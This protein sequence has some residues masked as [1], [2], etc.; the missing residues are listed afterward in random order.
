MMDGMEKRWWL[1]LRTCLPVSTRLSAPV[2]TNMG[3]R[4]LALTARIPSSILSIAL[5]ARGVARTDRRPRH[6]FARSE[7]YMHVGVS[8]V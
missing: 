5:K 7:R 1:L 3:S 6:D 4:F 2:L 8:G